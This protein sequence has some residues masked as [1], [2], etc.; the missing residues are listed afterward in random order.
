MHWS[1]ITIIGTV[2][3]LHM[4]VEEIW[5]SKYLL[6]TLNNFKLLWIILSISKMKILRPASSK[7]AM[8]CYPVAGNIT[9]PTE[10][11]YW[12]HSISTLSFWKQ[13]FLLIRLQWHKGLKYHSRWWPEKVHIVYLCLTHKLETFLN[14]L[15]RM[16]RLE[17]RKAECCITCSKF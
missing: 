9:L 1:V 3:T 5:K 6:Y 17:E 16:K 8:P 15:H 2:Q 14:N 7:R 11:Y 10:L 13:G 4:V 12:S